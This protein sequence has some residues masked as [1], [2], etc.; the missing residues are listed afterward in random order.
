MSAIV[1]IYHTNKEPVSI[2]HI[3]GMIGSLS[4]YPSDDVQIWNENHIF[5]G[6]HSQWITPES[7]GEPLPFYNQERKLVITADA[8][9]DNRKELFELLQIENSKRKI[10]PD[11]QLILLAYSKWGEDSPKYL[12]GD[13]AY[14]IWDE[15]EQKL[16]GARDFSG[17]RTLYY[18]QDYTRFVFSTVIHPIFTLPTIKK[19]INEQWLA[20]FLAIS[21]VIDTVDTSI[22]VYD[23]I[24]Q[25][26]PAHSFTI[27][28][29]RLKLNRYIT[30]ST[31]N[32]IKLKTNEDYEEAFLEVFER[33][34]H[35]RLRTHRNVGS[36]LSGGLDS[37]SIVSLA[38]KKLKKINKPLYTYTYHP[39][40]DFND[41]TPKNMIADER[42]LIKKTTDYIGEGL[43]S[44]FYDFNNMDP[45][46]EMD[47]F[48]DTLETPYKYFENSIWLKGVFQEAA[49]NDV[50]VLLNG[51]RGNLSISWGPPLEYYATLI[52]K[53]K[54]VQLHNEL[55]LYSQNIKVNR[56][57]LIPI[58]I[59]LAFPLINSLSPY[60][61]KYQ[62]RS[63]INPIFAEKHGVYKKLQRY[64]VDELNHSLPNLFKAKERHFQELF[65]W[66]TTNTFGCKFSLKYKLW[67]RDATND[68]RVIKF[69]LSVPE[70]QFVQSGMGRSLIRRVTKGLLPDQ[71][72]LNQ[73]TRGVQG[74][75]WVHRM[76]PTWNAYVKQLDKVLEN[77]FIFK[78]M[79][80]QTIENAISKVKEGPNIEF[81]NNP[82]YRIAMR[83]LIID[84]FL[85]T[86][87]GR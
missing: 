11:S 80:K 64:G 84:R 13:F 4:K 31:E 41:F 78:Y 20:E 61:E 27:H 32:K 8:I 50:G 74:V 28:N 47:D 87:E 43:I 19:Q 56:K 23:N 67:K 83:S 12:V 25:L 75:D 66:N 79:D 15:R 3:N 22:S 54:W 81:A 17:S 39:P 16:F 49:K 35:D 9:I 26:P 7:V 63:M 24:H 51:G 30:L 77:D 40:K 6:C 72:R 52:K 14:I 29:G 38:A 33:A 44:N 65:H 85:K 70:S 71:I 86:F 82:D 2:E 46:T 1:G 10:I 37:G 34:V 21:S 60:M 5:L 69:C 73:I 76:T 42:S 62:S 36:H 59:K 57:R 55:H 48:I 45:L 18:Y 58:I 53:L 68:L